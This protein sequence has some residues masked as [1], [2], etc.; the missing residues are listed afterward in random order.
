MYSC[1][2]AVL[3]RRMEP[4]YSPPALPVPTHPCTHL[5]HPAKARP[6]T[7]HSSL[8]KQVPS[9]SATHTHTRRLCW[10]PRGRQANSTPK[11]SLR[12]PRGGMFAKPPQLQDQDARRHQAAV[13]QLLSMQGKQGS[14]HE[15]PGQAPRPRAARSLA[16]TRTITD[17][18]WLRA[19]CLPPCGPAV[20]YLYYITRGLPK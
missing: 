18:L 15:G 10:R 17:K 13:S 9:G 12:A 4:R 3:T 2:P 7:Q 5:S 14:V 11:R 16:W 6:E 20:G 19:L 1:R 8:G